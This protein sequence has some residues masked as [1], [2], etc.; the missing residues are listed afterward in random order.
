MASD[1]ERARGQEI[2]QL[3]LMECY[4]R[5]HR[6][7]QA[8]RTVTAGEVRFVKDD[9]SLSRD[10]PSDFVYRPKALKPLA[11][12]VWSLSCSMG[13]LISASQ[14]FNRIKSVHVS[15]DGL[16]GGK[17]YIQKI[18]DMRKS[19]SEAIEHIS[20]TIDTIHDEINAP[21]WNP[22]TLEDLSPQ[23]QAEIEEMLDDSEEIL[24]NPEDYD[25]DRYKE[26]VV[27]EADTE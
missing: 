22:E 5:E 1:R 25:A 21:H 20:A 14:R 12:I 27:D 4:V 26:D 3:Y 17:G 7:R 9:G 18:T 15:P 13:H 16:L 19:L 23:D 8:R 10:R 2:A 24:A 11:K 6:A